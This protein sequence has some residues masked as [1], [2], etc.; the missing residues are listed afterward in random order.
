M[1]PRTTSD[2]FLMQ[3]AGVHG[4]RPCDHVVLCPR[5]CELS[6]SDARLWLC[7][8]VTISAS[9]SIYSCSCSDAWKQWTFS[10]AY[11]RMC[12]AARVS[13]QQKP[14]ELVITPISPQ[15]LNSVEFWTLFGSLDY[16]TVLYVLGHYVGHRMNM[17]YCTYLF[18]FRLRRMF[19]A[20]FITISQ[21]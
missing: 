4:S 21:R 6:P 7:R 16:K 14:Q 11:E 13:F 1:C 12:R 2:I 17:I 15:M 19:G 20:E 8:S 9:L 18:L 5:F 10:R 3:R